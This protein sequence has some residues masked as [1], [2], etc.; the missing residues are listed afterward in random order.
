[1][2]IKIPISFKDKKVL[3]LCSVPQYSSDSPKIDYW[4]KIVD[5]PWGYEYLM[6][7]NQFVAIWVLYLKQGFATSIHCH[8][9][10]ATSLIVLSGQVE[11]SSLNSQFILNE[12]DGVMIAKATFHSTKALSDGGAFVM[13]IETPPNK[14]DLIR[15]QDS[16]GRINSQYEICAKN[17]EK[18]LYHHVYFEQLIK[19][20]RFISKNF[21]SRNL[22]LGV[23]PTF[24]SLFSQFDLTQPCILCPLTKIGG[25][26][27]LELGKII[28]PHE[29]HNSFFKKKEIIDPCLQTLII[30]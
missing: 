2:I 19:P 16:N 13:E 9:H 27:S 8:P 17:K 24:Q 14:T 1:M 21:L 20:N 26:Q 5:K 10:K 7:Q 29:M 25:F 18:S 12:L 11:T 30:F 23:H 15:Y 4:Q 28:H 6:F 3:E 22:I